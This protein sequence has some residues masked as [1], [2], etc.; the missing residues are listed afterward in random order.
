MLGDGKFQKTNEKH[1]IF[2]DAENVCPECGSEIT[3]DHDKYEHICVRCGLVVQEVMID[4]G[5]EWRA[6]DHDQ[7]VNRARTGAP[8]KYAIADKGLP[9]T[10]DWRDKDIY[11]RAIPEKNKA[12]IH[13]IRRWNERMRVSRTGERNL[14]L[15]LG[16]LD[17][18]SSVLHLPRELRENASLIYRKASKRN[19][20]RGR[21]IECVVA[22]SIYMACRMFNIPRTFDE[23]SD[24]SQVSKKQIS[25]TYKFLAK[26]LNIKLNPTSP[27]DYISRF[28]SKLGLSCET[29]AK[30]ANI[31]DKTAKY[32]LNSG[33]GPTGVAAAAL[34]IASILSGEKKTQKDIAN[35]AGVTEVTIRNR[36]KELSEQMDL[37]AIF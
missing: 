3:F 2:I 11:G 30:A 22:S 19:L 28:A 34:Y 25:R 17:R 23:I 21:S 18:F 20:V 6:F 14:A 5:P 29:E 7:M 35:V 9:T 10:I 32:G 27:K 24:A 36:Y 26:K 1:S 8:A 15:A 4:Q 16:V 13:R 37:E 31:I 33:R 12:Q